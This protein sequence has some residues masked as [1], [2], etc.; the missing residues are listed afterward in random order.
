MDSFRP[1]PPRRARDDRARDDRARDDI[2][3]YI[4]SFIEG[5]F[6]LG[7]APVKGFGA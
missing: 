4:G 7:R 1:G 2:R 5:L 6:G 3:G